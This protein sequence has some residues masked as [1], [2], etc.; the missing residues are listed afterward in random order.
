MKPSS[1]GW[2]VAALSA[3]V[4]LVP[5]AT[6]SAHGNGSYGAT[7]VFTMTNSP[8]G[9]A[10]V[11]YE[12]SPSGALRWVGNFSS[13]GTGT[14]ASLASQGSLVVSDD[15]RWLIGVDAGSDQIS[16]FAIGSQHGTVA[17]QRTAIVSSGGVMPVSLATF[18]SVVYVLNVGNASGGG[19]IAGF[20]LTGSG[21]LVPIA[22][23]TEPLST[24]GPTGAAEIAYDPYPGA[25][26][27]T[28]KATNVIDVYFLGDGAAARPPLSFPSQ[29]G[30]P[31]GFAVSPTGAILV[32][33]A[34]SGS[35]SSYR[36]GYD[37]AWNVV[38][39]S[40]PDFQTAPCWVVTAGWGRNA[41][42]TN[43]DSNSISTYGVSWQGNLSL[44]NEVAA[45]TA[46]TP[47]D[48]SV[49]SDGSL[50]YVRDAG[51]GEIQGFEIGA[52]GSLTPAGSVGG[53]PASAEGLVAL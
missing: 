45:T 20:Y 19:D 52:D 13:G 16:V 12:R 3:A 48:L 1:L 2:I 10:I 22:G 30:T 17:L 37:G 21:G 27:V 6:A 47:T 36:F 50:L 43:A 29:G 38:S 24:P 42:T 7:A 41:Y 28:E 34:S 39:S 49:T 5:V 11:A 33:E 53:L 25:L 32:S 35:L 40:V 23:A 14:G 26:V 44:E 51:A 31:Y 46:S 18:G 15:Q 9:N 8:S 4:L